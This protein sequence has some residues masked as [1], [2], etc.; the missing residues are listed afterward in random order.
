MAI[1][2]SP[3]SPTGKGVTPGAPAGTTMAIGMTTAAA[4]VT[5]RMIDGVDTSAANLQ[6]VNTA[7]A[8]GGRGMRTIGAAAVRTAM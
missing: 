3:V 2:T 1:A 5:L 6:T 8:A 7:A 4:A